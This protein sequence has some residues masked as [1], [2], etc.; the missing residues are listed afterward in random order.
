MTL[1]MKP[2]ECRTALV[3]LIAAKLPVLLVGAPGG[4]KTSLVN[5]AC[6][7]AG[8][9][10][11]TAFPVTSDPTDFKGLPALVTGK[12]GRSLAEFLPYGDLR[13]L[14]E[15]KKPTVYFLDDLGQ[16]P[17]AVQAA[18]MQLIL[19]RRIGREQIS[20]EV[21]F[22]AASNRKED[23]AGVSGILEPVKSRFA[24]IMHLTHDVTDWTRDFAVPA[25]LPIELIAFCNMKPNETLGGFQASAEMRNSPCP[26]TIEHL[27]KLYALGFNKPSDLAILA[28]AV[29]EGCAADFLGFAEL[30]RTL[31]NPQLLLKDPST[32]DPSKLQ[33]KP[34]LYYAL[35]AILAQ[36]VTLGTMSAFGQL[37]DLMPGDYRALMMIIAVSR[38]PEL[39][40]TASYIAWAAAHGDT[41]LGN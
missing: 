33:D 16:A 17:P 34:A 11:L 29:G 25:K 20:D 38:A 30:F 23:R 21:R 2:S 19:A 39:R 8:A 14:L 35:A 32:F 31:P 3:K 37:C 7:K 5:W 13:L 12:N 18:A 36:Q 10:L 26:R 6:E 41:M 4:G 9:D 40:K 24:T 22:I 28:G 27:G 15:A 1:T